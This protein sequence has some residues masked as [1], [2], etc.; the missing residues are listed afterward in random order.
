M[1]ITTLKIYPNSY[2]LQESQSPTYYNVVRHL[3]EQGYR[4]TRLS[5][6]ARFSEK[7]FQF[8]STASEHLEFKHLL[9]QLVSDYCPH[10]MPETYCINDQ[11]W[12]L[13]LSQIAEKYYF[14]HN[15]LVDHLNNLVW[16]LKPA[17]LNNGQHIKIFQQL[18]QLEQHFI[19]SRRL[20][21]DHVLQRYITNPHL[22]RGHKYS[23][24]MFVVVTNYAGAY[25]YPHGYF[26]VAQHPYQP[27]DFIDLRSHLT[28]EHLEENELNVVQIPTQEFDFFPSIFPQIQTIISETLNSLK[29]LRPDAF[30]CAKQRSLAIFGFD[31]SV[32]VNKKVWL[33]E[34]NHGPCFPCN[35]EHPLQGH[36]YYNFWQAFIKSFVIPIATKQ[37]IE[38]IE[39]QL[40]IPII[41]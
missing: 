24:R 30:Y 4:Y 33:L 18:S 37:S 20:G 13:I 11:N 25:L 6:L 32:D 12:S 10:V 35:D 38:N 5:W 2:H 21:G 39:Y 19:S 28:N 29:K 22:L 9:A 31:F 8:S 1:K 14:A 17:L 23:I 36:L 34:A 3:Q 40:F 26:N 41:S 16:I 15:Q 27:N 7:N